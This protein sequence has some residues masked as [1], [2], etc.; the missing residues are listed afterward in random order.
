MSLKLIKILKEEV[1]EQGYGHYFKDW[2]TSSGKSVGDTRGFDF[3]T[4]KPFD[5]DYK[6]PEIKVLSSDEEESL[7]MLTTNQN[8]LV[9]IAKSKLGAPY[10]WG[11]NGPNSFDCSG[12]VRWVIKEYGGSHFGMP[13]TAHGMYEKAK[14]VTESDL[15]PGDL[16]FIDTSDRGYDYVDHVMM[17]I[18]PKGS[19]TIDAIHAEGSQGVNIEKDLKSSYY[20]NKIYG[21]GRFEI[22]GLNIPSS[23]PAEEEKV[24]V[25]DKAKKTIVV[26]GQS[27]ATKSWMESQWVSSGLSTKNVTFLDYTETT[28]FNNLISAGD[29]DKIIGFSAGGVLIWDQ[30]EKN[31]NKYS[32]IGLIDPTTPDSAPKS[33]S[34]TIVN[35]WANPETWDGGPNLRKT[36]NNLKN[37]ISLGL[38]TEKS[39]S[40]DKMPLEFFKNFKSKLS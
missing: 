19:N 38:A 1:T 6:N 26:G 37:L 8:R 21:Y 20:K 40:H 36:K 11:A 3:T 23:K 28:L 34:N 15:K 4:N 22:E 10:V 32:F 33:F 9:N 25:L 31:E 5:K 39:I 24:E 17:V 13:R 35:V 7:G 16:V 27:Y 14:K 2:K 12:Y 29:V 18:S 30:V